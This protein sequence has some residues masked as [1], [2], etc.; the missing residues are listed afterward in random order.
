[1]AMASGFPPAAGMV[2][3]ILGGLV[4]SRIKGSHLTITGP[5]AGLVTALCASVHTLGRGDIWTGYRHTLAAVIVAGVLQAL[6][7]L[8]KAGRTRSCFLP[9]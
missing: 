4:I 2:G 3:A 5:A 6:S 1:M 9:R 8:I 7:G